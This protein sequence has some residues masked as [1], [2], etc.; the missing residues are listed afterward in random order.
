MVVTEKKS[1]T[2][3]K[4]SILEPKVTANF[5][6]LKEQGPWSMVP[7]GPVGTM[8][9]WGPWTMGPW[10]TVHTGPWVCDWVLPRR[11]SCLTGTYYVVVGSMVVIEKMSRTIIKISFFE[12]KVTANFH[13]L[14]EQGPWTMVPYGPVWT[15]VPWGP[16][17]RGYDRK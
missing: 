11:I 5:H 4:I 2:I 15:V 13:T 6:T 10:T 17:S 7:Y 16:R 3:I 1:R 8:V 14:K 9:P 12:P